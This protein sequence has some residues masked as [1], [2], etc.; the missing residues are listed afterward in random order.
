MPIDQIRK[1]K[2]SKEKAKYCNLL[3]SCLTIEIKNV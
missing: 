1:P 3:T 2:I